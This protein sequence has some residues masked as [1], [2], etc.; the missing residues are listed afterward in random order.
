M[1]TQGRPPRRPGWDYSKP[2][3]Y[4]VTLTVRGWHPWFREA[5]RPEGPLTAAGS[6]VEDTW[7]RLPS[8][9]SRVQLD[10]IVIMPEHVHAVIILRETQG[11]S[12][13]LGEVVRYWKGF[14]R[15]KVKAA[16][17]EFGW[18]VGFYDRIVRS[19][20]ALTMVRRYIRQNPA[21]YT[22]PWA[23]LPAKPPRLL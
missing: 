6:V 4:F 17:P 16:H 14:T 21:N 12:T 13:P 18:R 19:Q 22:G 2:G 3:V 5:G 23:E 15:T 11:P 1:E 9:F 8:M 20:A 7:L 10:Q